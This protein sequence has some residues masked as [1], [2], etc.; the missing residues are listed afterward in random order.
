VLAPERVPLPPCGPPSKRS[1]LPFSKRS[2]DSGHPGVLGT[3]IRPTGPA[4]LAFPL[5]SVYYP[6]PPL[7]DRAPPRSPSIETPLLKGES[8]QWSLP[9]SPCRVA[10]FFSEI[11]ED[12]STRTPHTGTARTFLFLLF[13]CAPVEFPCDTCSFFPPSGR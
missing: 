6:L 12:A 4:A 9:F 1:F 2:L 5:V 3:C 10:S 7:P 8:H 11:A 13:S